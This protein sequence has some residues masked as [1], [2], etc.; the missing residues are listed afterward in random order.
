M[1]LVFATSAFAPLALGFF[2]LGTGYLI[3]GPEELFHWPKRNES[4][5]KSTGVWGIWLPGFCQLVT[6]IILFVGMTWFQVFKDAPLYMAALAFSAYGIHWFA[7]GYNRWQ[8]VDP[9]TNAGMSVAYTIISVLGIVVFFAVG[10]WP[11]GLLFVGLT[12]IYI[13]DFFHSIGQA[14]GERSLG[15]WHL[16]TGL[17]LM[18]L[19]F[20]TGLNFSLGMKLPL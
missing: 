3:Y 10:D 15:L 5:D 20:A 12:L 19:T 11:V 8:G 2:G 4:V 13:S 9:R 7:L 6:G 16:V 1:N 17:W 18:Y 14:W